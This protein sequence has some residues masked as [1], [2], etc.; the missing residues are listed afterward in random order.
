MGER[1]WGETGVLEIGTDW[2]PH[3]HELAK[4]AKKVVAVE[5]DSRLLPVLITLY[6][7]KN[8]KV[9]NRDILPESRP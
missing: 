3:S 7:N 2:R 4:R 1:R 8:V 6:R 9:I 5:L